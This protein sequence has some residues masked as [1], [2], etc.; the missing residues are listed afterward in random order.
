[1]ASFLSSIQLR[2]GFFDELCGLIAISL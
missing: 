2:S 1:M